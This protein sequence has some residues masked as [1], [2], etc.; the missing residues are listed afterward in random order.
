MHCLLFLGSPRKKG[1]TETLAAVV[2][3]VLE[4]NGAHVE[5]VRLCELALAPCIACGACRQNGRCII[6]DDMQNLYL[7]IDEADTI[8]IASPIYFYG[9]TAQTK[10]FIDR[11]QALWSRKY[12]LKK[13][14]VA[15]G[16]KPRR[17]YFLSVAATGGKKCFD[18]A[19]LTVRYCFDAM[20]ISW[21]GSLVVPDLDHRGAMAKAHRELKKAEVFARSLL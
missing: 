8:I 16:D 17:G 1:N 19:T 18:G 10:A 14:M 6:D 21:G 5:R 15:T 20:D 11:T 4:K 2:A 12:L 7:K 13:R 3:G 9:V